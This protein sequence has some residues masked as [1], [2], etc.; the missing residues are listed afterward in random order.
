M[1]VI[2]EEKYNER[3]VSNG[4]T[5]IFRELEKHGRRHVYGVAK[6]GYSC[7]IVKLLSQIWFND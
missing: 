6:I 1:L 7:F 3:C 5:A 4:Y 2:F